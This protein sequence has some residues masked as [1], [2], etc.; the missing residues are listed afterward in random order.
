M[1]SIVDALLSEVTRPLTP[2]FA[3]VGIST[4]LWAIS[5]GQ[6]VRYFRGHFEDSRGLVIF[7]G[8]CMLLSTLQFVDVVYF[9]YFQVIR[10]RL[11][12]NL[13]QIATARRIVAANFLHYIL[14]ALT[15]GFY[16]VRIWHVTNR[17]GVLFAIIGFLSFVQLAAGIAC[18]VNT[19]IIDSA[20]AVYDRFSH[21]AQGIASG[22]GLLCD[23]II[24]IA[25]VRF[26]QTRWSAFQGT[27]LALDK[28]VISAVN[29]GLL[30]SIFAILILITWLSAPQDTFLWTSFYYP[31]GQIYVNS[32]LV[33]LNA[34]QSLRAEL[35]SAKGRHLH[36]FELDDFQGG[37]RISRAI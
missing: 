11:P 19:A 1:A 23:I 3:S 36:T 4:F 7:L 31:A 29:I 28:M 20:F 8:I 5:V 13:P 35:R 2:I 27:R 21:I 37:S 24:T 25:L 34:R 14:T 18:T 33:C 12:V 16:A 15:Q 10:C 22:T 6:F 32:I 26:L 9:F 17:K 30:T